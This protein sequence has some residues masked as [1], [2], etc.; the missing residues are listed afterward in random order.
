MQIIQLCKHC[1]QQGMVISHVD[2]TLSR[3]KTHNGT[4]KNF[5]N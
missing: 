2:F 4:F 5:I 3:F 1:K